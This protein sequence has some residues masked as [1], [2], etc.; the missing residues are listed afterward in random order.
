MI[1]RLLSELRQRGVRIRSDGDR[2]LCDAPPNVMTPELMEKIR[3]HKEQIIELL[4][5]ETTAAKAADVISAISRTSEIPL[6]FAQESLWFLDQLKSD[7]ASYNIPIKLRLVGEIDAELLRRSLTEIVRRHEI[8]RTCFRTLAGRPIQVITAPPILSVPVIDLTKVPEEAR[9]EE[10]NRLCREQAERPFALDRDLMLRAA[11]FKLEKEKY[12]LLLNL[13]H[14]AS[15][16]WS[17][18]ILLRELGTIYEAFSKGRPSPLK[19]LPVQYADFAAWQRGRLTGEVYARQLQYWK[20]QMDGALPLLDLPTEWP[21]PLVQ[22]FRGAVEID[23]DT[24]RVDD[25]TQGLEP[26]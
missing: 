20:R 10:A 12:I 22:T 3:E 2:V 26:A 21:R 19:E 11:L 15:D 9:D 14:I 8:L 1:E 25:C 17:L 5:N 18:D 23:F 16:A 13:H 24:D 6:S 4:N 7:S